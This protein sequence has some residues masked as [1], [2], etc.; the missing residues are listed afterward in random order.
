M[1]PEV[2]E[3]QGETF[4]VVPWDFIS[5]YPVGQIGNTRSSFEERKEERLPILS[6]PSR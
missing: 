4:E 5:D 1:D 6:S 2:F 3:Y